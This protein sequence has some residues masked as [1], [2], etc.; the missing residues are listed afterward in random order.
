[1]V[2]SPEDVLGTGAAAR[3]WQAVCSASRASLTAAGLG[4]GL[5]PGLGTGP[6]ELN[7]TPLNSLSFK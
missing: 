3:W 7:S 6:S 1:M 5:P 2:L 4:S